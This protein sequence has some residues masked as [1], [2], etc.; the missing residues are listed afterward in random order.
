LEEKEY[1]EL[2]ERLAREAVKAG[3][4]NKQIRSLYQ[5]AKTNPY[6]RFETRL[7]YQI[8]RSSGYGH[9]GPRGFD[10]FG[11]LLIKE[12]GVFREDKVGLL[13]VLW[14][15]TMLYAYEESQ[16]P[17]PEGPASRSSTG[18]SV[19]LKDLEAKLE[20]VV[21]GLCSQYGVAGLNVSSEG[22]NLVCS[23]KLLRFTGN[24][25]ALSDNLAA[26]VSSHLPEYAGR[27]R[28]WIESSY[29]RV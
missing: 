21:R 9:G 16:P 22:A 5:L 18:A 23:V 14:Y 15:M 3:V 27:I 8:G 17:S 2:G 29:G 12:L 1:K 20:P 7:K 11:K 4:G 19:T 25:R 10:V 26:S 28:F 13:K 6:E 24:P